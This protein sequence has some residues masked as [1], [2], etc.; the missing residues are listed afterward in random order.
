M[1]FSA[2]ATQANPLAGGFAGMELDASLFQQWDDQTVYQIGG[3]YQ[4]NKQ[5]TMR[6]GYNYAANPVP[7][8]YMNA[9]FPA[10][11][12]SHITAGFGYAFNDVQGI[13]FSLQHAPEVSAT[14]PGVGATIPAVT[15]RHSQTSF[16]FIYSQRF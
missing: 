10:I 8:R 2:D 11:V 1:V 6:A 14:N 12:E 13:D 4:V 9:L 16:Q 3:A 7:D 5:L 15:S